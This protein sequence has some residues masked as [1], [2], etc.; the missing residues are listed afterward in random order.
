MQ[1]AAQG[2]QQPRYLVIPRTLIF[3]THG[4]AVLLLKGA[5]HKRLWAGK[6]N[7]LGGHIEPGEDPY[8]AACREVAE[9]AG[10]EVVALTLRAIIHVT[11]PEPPGVLFFTFTG[12]APAGTLR[13]SAEG[14]PQ[15]IGRDALATLPLV[16]DLYTLLPQVL[17]PGPLLYGDYHFTEAGLVMQL[18]PAPLTPAASDAG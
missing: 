17:E 10:L 2:N 11:L 14:T 15:W 16:E 18:T 12:E 6:F 9:E 4:E 5:P 1:P 7:G 8:A 13:P 3:L